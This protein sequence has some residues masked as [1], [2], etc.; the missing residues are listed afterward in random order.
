MIEPHT[1][2]HTRKQTGVRQD[3]IE[4]VRRALP[5]VISEGRANGMWC[6]GGLGVSR[7]GGVSCTSPVAGTGA[8]GSIALRA[9]AGV[10]AAAALALSRCYGDLD[11]GRSLC[12]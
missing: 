3:R 4:Q 11:R 9:V 6:G 2:T 12:V 10:K 5:I 7:G 1:H 8:G